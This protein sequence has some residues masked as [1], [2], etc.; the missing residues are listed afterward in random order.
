M[1][2]FPLA[3]T[4]QNTCPVHCFILSSMLVWTLSLIAWDDRLWVS[5]ANLHSQKSSKIKG[6]RGQ[7]GKHAECGDTP[8]RWSHD[9]TTSLERVGGFTGPPTAVPP[10]ATQPRGSRELCCH[11]LRLKYTATPIYSSNSGRCCT[12]LSSCPVPY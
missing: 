12:L 11:A 1:G 4:I 5:S 8:A 2:N 7:K 6:D 10:T 9:V 3:H